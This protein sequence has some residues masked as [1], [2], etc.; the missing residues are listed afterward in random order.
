MRYNLQWCNDFGSAIISLPETNTN[1]NLP[2]QHLYLSSAL[3]HLWQHSAYQTPCS[4]EDF[5]SQYQPGGT[6]TIVCGN[7]TSRIVDRGEDPLGLG[8]WSYFSL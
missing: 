3:C 7:W 8:R 2:D 4:P 6:T 5:L 1:W